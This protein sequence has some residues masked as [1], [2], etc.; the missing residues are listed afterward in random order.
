MSRSIA[1]T[2]TVFGQFPTVTGGRARTVESTTMLSK[3]LEVK[4]RHH[5]VWANY[6]VRWGRGTRDVFYTTGTG[7]IAHDSVRSIAADDYFYK[8]STLTRN[9]VQ[10]IAGFS[11]KSPDHLHRQHMSYLRDVLKIQEA[12]EIYRQSEVQNQEVERH[13]HA[14]KCNLMEN[15]HS[16]H[17]KAA[18]PVL[19][20]LADGDLD[21][22]HDNQ[23]MVQFLTFIGQQFCR[24]KAFRDNALQVLNRRSPLEI[25]V[26]D[27][28]AHSWW[29]LSYMYG[30]N[31]GW[32]LYAGRH[33]ATHAL[34]INDT[35]V[36]FI[37]SDHPVVNVHSCVS[38]TEFSLPEHAD[39]YYPI[40]PRVAYIICDSDRFTQGKN[41]VD[42]AIVVELN[43]KQAA[44]AMVHIIGDTEDAI[45]PYRK[46]VGRRYQKA[47][48]GRVAV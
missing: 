18:L 30:M 12:E 2:V 37:T 27:A 19:A 9:H 47:L 20:A 33:E 42:E 45:R 17:E 3:Y 41:R 16:S 13:L 46:L 10:V 26:A 23:R 21:F 25:E 38:E 4:K 48:R 11:R 39:L 1:F 40:S 15:L 34:L 28:M 36:P 44:Q 43:S 24:T 14:A 32:S 8:M 29:F 7:K 22:L 35:P 6:L 5:Y 31:L